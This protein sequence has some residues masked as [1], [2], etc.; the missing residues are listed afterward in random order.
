MLGD[1]VLVVRLLDVQIIVVYLIVTSSRIRKGEKNIQK[2][3]EMP[4]VIVGCHVG[5]GGPLLLLRWW[6]LLWEAGVRCGLQDLSVMKHL[7]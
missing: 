5:D 6:C 4:F 3:P 2:R 7:K 1:M